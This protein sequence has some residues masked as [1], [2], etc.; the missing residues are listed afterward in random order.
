MLRQPAD[1]S[2]LPDET[3]SAA[4][5]ASATTTRSFSTM[6]LERDAEHILVGQRLDVHAQVAI[7]DL[8]GNGRGVAQIVGHAGE[9]GVDQ[10]LDLVVAVDRDRLVQIADRDRVGQRASTVAGRG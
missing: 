3:F 5:S 6:L 7:G 9:Q 4:L 1:I 10:I 8:V 2:W